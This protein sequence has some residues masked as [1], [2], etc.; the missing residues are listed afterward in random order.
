MSA[1]FVGLTGV[2][3]LPTRGNDG[4]GEVRLSHH[5]GSTFSCIAWSDAALRVGESVLAVENL[6]NQTVF[7]VP[8]DARLNT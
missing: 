3:T 2:I 6:E 8:F 5:N 1:N 7:V 4:A